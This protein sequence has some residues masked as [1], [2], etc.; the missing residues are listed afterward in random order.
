[1]DPFNSSEGLG[2]RF[3]NGP[4]LLFEGALMMGVSSTRISNAARGIGNNPDADFE[5]APSGD[6]YIITPGSKSDQESMAT[7]VDSKADNPMNLRIVQETYAMADPPYDDF[8]IFLYSV[9]YLGADT[10]KNFHF[11]MYLDWDM[12]GANYKTNKVGYDAARKLGY[13]YDTGDGPK[14]YVG[15]MPLTGG[16]VNYRGIYND[17]ND[18]H[19]PPWGTYDGYT[20][21]EKW[22]SLSGGIQFPD[23]GPGDIAQVMALGPFDLTPGNILELGFALLGGDS[24]ADLQQ[25]AD[26]ARTLWAKLF[27]T[28]LHNGESETL[29]R[30]IRLWQN[31]P[32]PFN[33][34]TIIRY[35]IP[36]GI[37]NRKVSLFIYN[38]LGER[39]RSFQ[40]GNQKAGEYRVTWDGK[41]DRGEPVPSGIYFYTLKV[42]QQVQS[43][44]MVLIR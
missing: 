25:N 6:L 14:T 35:S 16:N 3:K 38:T 29:P 9:E 30:N 32:N 43:R 41:N 21:Q 15:V 17:E 18:P 31:Y 36:P 1:V 11:G 33:P 34:E 27:P 10:L 7:F 19:N 8:I 4:N 2:F 39:V 24:L 23:A 42:G 22:E 5:V 20:D 26:S 28:A 44:K 37:T 40:L 12:D 13:A